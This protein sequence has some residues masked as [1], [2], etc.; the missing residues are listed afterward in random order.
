MNKARIK[1]YYLSK[2]LENRKIAAT[3]EYA[4]TIY[5]SNY[6]CHCVMYKG[7]MFNPLNLK[8]REIK[9]V[10]EVPEDS[11]HSRKLD[12]YIR[13]IEDTAKVTGIL[14]YILNYL[15]TLP[16]FMYVVFNEGKPSEEDK[17]KLDTFKN[18]I[19]DKLSYLKRIRLLAD[20][21]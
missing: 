21:V 5:N 16:Q 1:E 19:N 10:Y 11:E 13:V 12:R 8:P 3:E 9:G 18:E 4:A 17:V 2:W 20:M 14:T 7:L 6:D 15:E